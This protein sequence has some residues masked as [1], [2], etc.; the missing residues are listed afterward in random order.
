MSWLT[1]IAAGVLCGCGAYLLM[2]R[3]L[4]RVIVGFGLMGHGVNLVL[5]LSGGE[6]GEPAFVDAGTTATDVARFSDPL[7]QAFVLTAIVISFGVVAFL[8]ALAY[9]SW[10]LSGADDVE[11]DLED[12][13][14]AAPGQRAD[15][16]GAAS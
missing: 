15:R 3:Q 12:R 16:N 1:I 14:I 13:R 5:V 6:R 4:S 11:D 8:L 7:P 9:R 2:S 10:C